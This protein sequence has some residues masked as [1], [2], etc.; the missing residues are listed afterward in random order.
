MREAECV[1]EHDVRVVN[2]GVF[3]CYPF[4][5][6]AGGLTGR[7]GYVAAGGINLLIVV[8]KMLDWHT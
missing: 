8:Y 1:P 2:R 3:V 5:N 4:W 6:S 7:L